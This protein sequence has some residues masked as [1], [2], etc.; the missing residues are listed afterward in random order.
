[1]KA[2]FDGWKREDLFAVIEEAIRRQF[3]WDPASK[4]L[5]PKDPEDPVSRAFAENVAFARLSVKRILRY[6]EGGLH[7][8]TSYIP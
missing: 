8:K 5:R 4:T 6:V 7:R 3:V 1:M 2:R